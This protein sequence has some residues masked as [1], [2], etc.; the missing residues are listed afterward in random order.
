MRVAHGS[1]PFRRDTERSDTHEAEPFLQRGDDNHDHPAEEVSLQR[2]QVLA[3][4]IAFP[5]ARRIPR[6]TKR[7][8]RPIHSKCYFE[9]MHQK[10]YIMVC[11]RYFIRL[12]NAAAVSW[13]PAH[14]GN[15]VRLGCT[16]SGAGCGCST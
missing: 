6:V 11:S 15:T 9:N 1:Q 5:F 8:S 10:H 14:V 4:R 13:T 16:R 2:L 3:R 12:I 7:Y